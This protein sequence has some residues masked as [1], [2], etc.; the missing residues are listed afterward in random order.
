MAVTM[1]VPPFAFGALDEK[2]WWHHPAYGGDQAVESS[3]LILDN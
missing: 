3:S 2:G 1:A